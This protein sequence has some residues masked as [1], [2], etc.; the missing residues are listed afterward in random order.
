MAR[1]SW[2]AWAVIVGLMLVLPLFFTTNFHRHLLV[3][4]AINLVLVIS[5]DIVVGY[6]GLIALSQI[7]FAGIGAY[8]SAILTTVHRTQFVW[9]FLAAGVLAS[10]TGL[11]FAH[12]SRRLRGAYFA[13]TTFVFGIIAHVLFNN[14][15]GLTR[16]PMGITAIPAPEIWLPGAGRVTFWDT[17]SY[18]YLTVV[19]VVIVMIVREW[20]ARSRM[21]RSLMAIREN[22]DLA[23]SVGINSDRY[24]VLGFGISSF[25]AGIG[26]SLHAHYLSFIGPESFTFNQSVEV[27]LQNVLGGAATFTGPFLGTAIV[28][29][30]KEWARNLSPALAEIAFGLVLILTIAFLPTGIVGEWRRLT[31]R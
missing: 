23:E 28:T 2:V 1:R 21:G 31:R 30:V 24:K 5:L 3:V 15:M 18:Y 22:E 27:F 10:L 17:R 16:G 11:A 26:G 20:I 8:T 19:V 9:A 29:V 12:V 14:L 25:F 7:A 6:A 4:A 13:V